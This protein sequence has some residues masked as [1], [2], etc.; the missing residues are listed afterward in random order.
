MET[1]RL[2]VRRLGQK[3]VGALVRYLERDRLNNL[4]HLAN[5][6]QLGIEHPELHY[7]GA[8]RADGA[9]AGELMRFR[10]SAG[11][12]WQDR[13][14]LPQFK[15]IIHR[16]KASALTGQSTQVD[17]LLSLLPDGYI[18]ECVAAT[19]A[20]VG[21][22]EL[23]PWPDRGER[24]ATL[25]DLDLLA[26]LY[27]RNLLFGK[28]DWRKHRARIESVL[29]TGGI[30]TLVERDGLAVSA[31]RTSA[32]GHGM[33]MIGGVITLPAYRRMG[34]ARACTGL[35]SRQLIERGVDSCLNY[36]AADPAASKTY[37]GL[38]YR[39]IGKWTIAFLN[40]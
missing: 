8:F 2:T 23:R 16:E 19:Y 14:V 1:P 10:S 35:L 6:D 3:D 27:A 30:I 7:Y 22:G 17:P 18:S 39:T 36:S 15:D 11:I 4:F 29:A 21:A 40:A 33:A 13:R 32:I 38:G 37:L 20:L 28:L 24:L 25:D 26:D 34:F 12:F 31:A 9:W 5:L